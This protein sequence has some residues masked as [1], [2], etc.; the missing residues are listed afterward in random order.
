MNFSYYFRIKICNRSRLA[1]S[2]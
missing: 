2:F 1:T